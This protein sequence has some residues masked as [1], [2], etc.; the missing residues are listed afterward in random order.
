MRVLDS[1]TYTTYFDVLLDHF[2]TIHPGEWI[3]QTTDIPYT[4]LKLI[5]LVDSKQ[6]TIRFR[7]LLNA[8][9]EPVARVTAYPNDLQQISW[10]QQTKGATYQVA[11]Q[12]ALQVVVV[13]LGAHYAPVDDLLFT[14][15]GGEFVLVP[16]IHRI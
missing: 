8:T 2:K 7:V 9:Q 3:Y 12:T 13:E 6:K 15:S 1:T 4:H 16:K 5:D 14:L 10:L 11:E